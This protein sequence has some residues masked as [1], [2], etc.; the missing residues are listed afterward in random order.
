MKLGL[1]AK[2]EA[3]ITGYKANFETYV[4]EVKKVIDEWKDKVNT[5]LPEY[6]K[7]Q[8]S[9]EL[10]A[11]NANY[12][13]SNKTYNQKLWAVIADARL[14]VIPKAPV[15]PA[16]YATKVSNAITLL[17]IKGERITD[18]SAFM[19]LKDFI[20]D[21]DTMRLFKDII[22]TLTSRINPYGLVDDSGNAIFTKTFGKLNE[23][24]V[25]LNTFEEIEASADML[26]IHPKQD[27]ETYIINGQSYSLPIDSYEQMAGEDDILNWAETIDELVEAIPG[28]GTVTD[29]TEHEVI[30]EEPEEPEQIEN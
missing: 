25:L 10:A 22:E 7:E 9:L 24:Q 26:F 17:Q 6:I 18:D 19:I 15:K 2:I 28:V 5:H 14:K 11:L 12:S 29:D 3:I 27:G 13:K 20:D 23:V 1:K 8:I 30:V 16:D 21:Y 4:K